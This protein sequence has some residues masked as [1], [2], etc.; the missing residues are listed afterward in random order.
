VRP[1]RPDI[2]A[3][4]PPGRL[5][6]LNADEP[7]RMAELCAR[8]PVLVHFFDFAQL[9]SVRALPYPV[10]WDERYRDLGLTTLGVNT[11][12]FPFSADRATLAGA[13]ERFGVTHAVALDSGYALWHDYG[14]KGWPSLFLW[15]R[16]GA[17]SWA[18][19]GEGEYAATEEAIQA[20]LRELNALVELPAPLEPLRPSDAAGAMVVPPSEEVLP[21]AS[22]SEPWRGG[23]D[24]LELG[25][26]AAGA[27]ASVAGEGELRVSLDG[28]PARAVRPDGPGLV[29]LAVHP[30]HEHHKLRLEAD[31]G[32][33]VYSVSFSPG[34]P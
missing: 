26:S 9:N 14:C 18:H 6:W 3:P 23:S 22:I 32:V 24:P 21:G 34:P 5:T 2:A 29:D 19:F 16:G 8:G 17:L 4:E 28:E 13:L 15:A 33:E 12:R 27:H 30:R 7:P 1:D 20:E 11:P 25:Y 10:A 31:R